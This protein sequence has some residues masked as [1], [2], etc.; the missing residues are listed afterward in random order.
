MTTSLEELISLAATEKVANKLLEKGHSFRIGNAGLKSLLAGISKERDAILENLG[1]R[2]ISSTTTYEE[3][4]FKCPRFFEKVLEL[5]TAFDF[6]YSRNISNILALNSF[7]SNAS[8]D[9]VDGDILADV[10]TKL[11]QERSLTRDIDRE[12]DTQIIDWGMFISSMFSWGENSILS[13]SD[14]EAARDLKKFEADLRRICQSA[15]EHAQ[16]IQNKVVE[17]LNQISIDISIPMLGEENGNP[18]PEWSD[19]VSMVDDTIFSLHKKQVYL[20]YWVLYKMFTGSESL[21]TRALFCVPAVLNKKTMEIDLSL[22]GSKIGDNLLRFLRTDFIRLT[23]PEFDIGKVTRV[24]ECVNESSFKRANQMPRTRILNDKEVVTMLDELCR[25]ILNRTQELDNEFQI[26]KS[27]MHDNLKLDFSQLEKLVDIENELYKVKYDFG[28]LS[29]R[30]AKETICVAFDEVQKQLVS[31]LQEKVYVLRKAEAELQDSKNFISSKGWDS[32]NQ[33]EVFCSDTLITLLKKSNTRK[34]FTGRND[35]WRDPL[36]TVHRLTQEQTSEVWLPKLVAADRGLVADPIRTKEEYLNLRPRNAKNISGR[37]ELYAGLSPNATPVTSPRKMEQQTTSSPSTAQA[38]VSAPSKTPAPTQAPGKVPEPPSAPTETSPPA[39]TPIPVPTKGQSSE[40]GRASGFSTDSSASSIVVASSARASKTSNPSVIQV[41]ENI[42]DSKSMES[43]LGLTEETSSPCSVGLQRVSISFGTA[44]EAGFSRVASPNAV[45]TYEFHESHL[46]GLL[47]RFPFLRHEPVPGIYLEDLGAFGE[48][49]RFRASVN[50]LITTKNS[51]YKCT[52]LE[53]QQQENE[54]NRVVAGLAESLCQATLSAVRELPFLSVRVFRTLLAVVLPFLNADEKFQNLLRGRD[55]LLNNLKNEENVTTSNNKNNSNNGPQ[56]TVVQTKRSAASGEE[57]RKIERQLMD[58]AHEIAMRNVVPRLDQERSSK[59]IVLLQ[60]EVLRRM[61]MKNAPVTPLGSST[62]PKNQSQVDDMGTKRPSLA[63]SVAT[64]TVL[65]MESS[66]PN[67]TTENIPSFGTVASIP[68]AASS[69]PAAPAAVPD[70]GSASGDRKSLSPPE[71]S[72]SISPVKQEKFPGTMPAMP[73]EGKEHLQSSAQRSIPVTSTTAAPSHSHELIVSSSSSFRSSYQANAQ[74]PLGVQQTARSSVSSPVSLTAAPESVDRFA[75]PLSSTAEGKRKRREREEKDKT[76]GDMKAMALPSVKPTQG[77]PGV[78]MSGHSSS[79]AVV[80]TPPM[81]GGGAG[82]TVSSVSSPFTS[83]P[84]SGGTGGG[85]ASPTTFGGPTGHYLS[86]PHVPPLQYTSSTSP[87]SLPPGSTAAGTGGADKSRGDIGAGGGGGSGLSTSPR[88]RLVSPLGSNTAATQV[89]SPSTSAAPLPPRAVVA[90]EATGRAFAD[91][92]GRGGKEN[93]KKIALSSPSSLLSPHVNDRVEVGGGG[94]EKGKAGAHTPDGSPPGG[95]SMKPVRRVGPSAASSLHSLKP[96]TPVTAAPAEKAA[97]EGGGGGGVVGEG[98]KTTAQTAGEGGRR[99][100]SD[101]VTASSAITIVTDA[102]TASPTFPHSKSAGDIHRS[103]SKN[104]SRSSST[105]S[106]SSSSSSRNALPIGARLNLV[107]LKEIT[108]AASSPGRRLSITS[109]KAGARDGRQSSLAVSTVETGE[110]GSSSRTNGSTTMWATHYT[111]ENETYSGQGMETEESLPTSQAVK[112]TKEPPVSSFSTPTTTTSSPSPSFSQDNTRGRK[113]GKGGR[114]SRGKSGG[115]T[116]STTASSTVDLPVRVAPVEHRTSS[117]NSPLLPPSQPSLSYPTTTTSPTPVAT[118]TSF[119]SPPLPYPPST[120]MGTTGTIQHQP[121]STTTTATAAPAAPSMVPAPLF[122]FTLTNSFA[123]PLGELSSDPPHEPSASAFLGTTTTS[124]TMWGSGGG[125]E[126]AGGGIGMSDIGAVP[127]PFP[128]PLVFTASPSSPSPPSEGSP[129]SMNG[130]AGAGSLSRSPLLSSPERIPHSSPNYETGSGNNPSLHPSSGSGVAG[131]TPLPNRVGGS[132]VVGGGP[133]T[134]TSSCLPRGHQPSGSVVI[135]MSPSPTLSPTSSTTTLLNGHNDG[136]VSTSSF[137]TSAIPIT[138]TS[139]TT[140]G[141]ASLLP[142]STTSTTNNY[143]CSTSSYSRNTTTSHGGGGKGPYYFL[144]SLPSPTPVSAHPGSIGE[145]TRGSSTR[146][147]SGGGRSISGMGVDGSSAPAQ[148]SSLLQLFPLGPPLPPCH[149]SPS[150]LPVPQ[151]MAATIS[152]TASEVAAKKMRSIL[153]A[154]D[155]ATTTNDKHHWKSASYSGVRNPPPQTGLPKPLDRSRL[156]HYTTPPPPPLNANDIPLAAPSNLWTGGG[157]SASRE[158]T[159]LSSSCTSTSSLP[160]PMGETSHLNE[161]HHITATADSSNS[162][163][164]FSDRGSSPLLSSNSGNK[165]VKGPGKT[166]R[167]ALITTTTNRSSGGGDGVGSKSG[168]EVLCDATWG[169]ST[170]NSSYNSRPRMN[171]NRH[172]T[173]SGAPTMETKKP[174]NPLW[175]RMHRSTPAPLISKEKTTT[176]KNGGDGRGAG[177]AAVPSSSSSLPS[178]LHHH[179]GKEDENNEHT[180]PKDHK[181]PPYGPPATAAASTT[182]H[183]EELPASAEPTTGTLAMQPLNHTASFSPPKPSGIALPPSSLAASSFLATTPPVTAALLTRISSTPSMRTG[184]KQ[185]GA[186]LHQSIPPPTTADNTKITT[187]TTTPT[188]GCTANT[189][190]SKDDLL[191]SPFDTM[192][193][194]SSSTTDTGVKGE[195]AVA[196][197]STVGAAT[198]TTASPKASVASPITKTASP[199]AAAAA[200]AAET[201]PPQKVENEMT[202]FSTSVPSQDFRG[203]S[204]ASFGSLPISATS[205]NHKDFNLT[206]G[207][208]RLQNSITNGVVMKKHSSLSP[209][210]PKKQSPTVALLST[211]VKSAQ[212]HRSAPQHVGPSPSSPTSTSASP[213]SFPPAKVGGKGPATPTTPPI[214]STRSSS[215]SKARP[216]STSNTTALPPAHPITSSSSSNATSTSSVKK[217]ASSS[218]LSTSDGAAASSRKAASLPT[219]AAPTNST[220]S[221][222]PSSRSP[223]SAV[224]SLAVQQGKQTSF[225]R[226]VLE[227]RKEDRDGA[228]GGKCV[229]QGNTNTTAA[230]TPPITTSSTASSSNSSVYLSSKQTPSPTLALPLTPNLP[231]T[232]PT[233]TTS[234]TSTTTTT[235]FTP[236]PPVPAAIPASTFSSRKVPSSRASR[237]H[238]SVSGNR[239]SVRDGSGCS[240]GSDGSSSGGGKRYCT[241]PSLLL[242]HK[243]QKEQLLQQQQLLHERQQQEAEE[244]LRHKAEELK[245]QLHK[246]GPAGSGAPASRPRPAVESA[247]GSR[248]TL[249]SPTATGTVTATTTSAAIVSGGK[250]VE[251]GAGGSRSDGVGEPERRGSGAASP[252]LP[253]YHKNSFATMHNQNHI[254]STAVQRASPTQGT[255]SLSTSSLLSFPVSPNSSSHYPVHNSSG[256]S[257]GDSQ[258]QLHISKHSS[259]SGNLKSK[260][261]PSAASTAAATN[262][263]AAAATAAAASTMGNG[264]MKNSS[265]SSSSLFYAHLLQA[266][267]EVLQQAVLGGWGWRSTGPGSPSSSHALHNSGSSGRKRQESGSGEGVARIGSNTSNDYGNNENARDVHNGSF[268]A[269]GSLNEAGGRSF[270]PVLQTSALVPLHQSSSNSSRSSNAL[271]NIP[272][273]KAEFF[274]PVSG[275]FASVVVGNERGV[276]GGRHCTPVSNFGLAVPLPGQAENADRSQRLSSSYSNGSVRRQSPQSR[277]AC[278]ALRQATAF[279]QGARQRPVLPYL[280]SCRSLVDI[281]QHACKVLGLRP[282]SVLLRTFPSSN[283]ARLERIDMSSN[284]VG[285]KGLLPLFYVIEAN[286]NELVHLNLSSNNLENAEVLELLE[287]LCGDAGENLSCL[288]LSYNPISQSGGQAILRLTKARPQ[289]VSIQ[290]KGTLIPPRLLQNIVENVEENAFRQHIG[291]F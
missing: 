288:D 57:I 144:H 138:S 185:G 250:T 85:G 96:N 136:T 253:I 193:S 142:P 122:S 262:A 228:S 284:Y 258:V 273:G 9:S 17:I 242:Q 214:P 41:T 165:L 231:S 215:S 184:W 15:G 38:P 227:I 63:S 97:R 35:K 73:Q 251:G 148:G 182:R 93:E 151:A 203:D 121:T 67:R 69:P 37:N 219:P 141:P 87:P 268:S 34:T 275:S 177:A 158:N 104:S 197:V 168:K 146:S 152:T 52:P 179:V 123:V 252:P 80:S 287:V 283:G 171:M 224:S 143:P 62:W 30:F 13:E 61:P 98:K 199:P 173:H 192:A 153:S 241:I 24:V 102:T 22:S 220:S 5:I 3:N 29:R 105:S 92:G 110:D 72:S 212:H 100:K 216:S 238:F 86:P 195:E 280:P 226:K 279:A 269:I 176:E 88:S 239:F 276:S 285:A 149:P 205:G 188:T 154:P 169:T 163:N 201:A 4:M 156:P 117:A 128:A 43:E 26:A 39:K 114:G 233:P 256:G 209:S 53:V 246:G 225:E 282:N 16:L 259:T 235:T 70:H 127:S 221:N 289:L 125:S 112:G 236:P 119:A 278:E 90:A 170:P 120:R 135:P 263:A 131:V 291:V 44:S 248:S 204:D 108:S 42:L 113:E 208:T 187:T 181:D 272:M 281:Y 164:S 190:S 210:P 266:Q 27:E 77:V 56:D 270:S 244:N 84:L 6:N 7:G 65:G 264:S 55:Q 107:R 194:T 218:T 155:N 245:Q 217:V 25:M 178:Q 191:P 79:L 180:S 2:Y 126:V 130:S 290:L 36:I 150:P 223:V 200:A 129:L 234:T 54:I 249:A 68:Q 94:N 58:V 207:S 20:L 11:Q 161:H 101:F 260:T 118:T 66:V 240:T 23:T 76:E 196:T 137:S 237:P 49:S 186:A 116:C 48:N 243:R 167:L 254:P 124:S 271:E 166:T 140:A 14:Y 46:A 18:T 75:S 172:P 267:K 78:L 99:G 8:V 159:L 60:R 232:T 175:Q 157:G 139:L 147:S 211:L 247:T 174:G 115:T 277:R 12:K 32:I 132:E 202:L 91:A 222:K 134:T 71:S 189:E 50:C 10:V 28:V 21:T 83:S 109:M 103:S 74:G 162:N 206:G 286:G 81:G 47:C 257:T 89:G 1:N 183:H 59:S 160:S 229:G 40:S 31:Q 45:T 106:S 82:G 51:G 133:T 265:N 145:Y 274:R 64:E 261:I 255:S 230:D 111:R 213:S 33:E 95:R 19:F 198:T